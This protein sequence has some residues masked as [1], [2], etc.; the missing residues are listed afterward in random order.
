MQQNP[1]NNVPIAEYLT[2]IATRDIQGRYIRP[3]SDVQVRIAEEIRE[4]TGCTPASLTSDV[5]E[6]QRMRVSAKPER[7]VGETLNA[8]EVICAALKR[9]GATKF[10]LRF[11]NPSE[12]WG[13]QILISVRYLT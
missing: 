10:E 2:S 8:I 3:R 13:D 11:S 12:P 1:S 4:K 7:L 9:E 5:K 6:L